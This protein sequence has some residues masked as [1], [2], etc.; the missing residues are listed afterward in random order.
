MTMT[1]APMEDIQVNIRISVRGD[2]DIK[3]AVQGALQGASQVIF[4][5]SDDGEHYTIN[6]MFQ[7]SPDSGASSLDIMVHQVSDSVTPLLLGPSGQELTESM[8][9]TR[10]RA[11]ELWLDNNLLPSAYRKKDDGSTEADEN[12]A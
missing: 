4:T 10:A 9:K 5:D 6:N 2:S 3:A 12:A 8:K 7:G 11:Y 1:T